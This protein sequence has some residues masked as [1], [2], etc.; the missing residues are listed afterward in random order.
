MFTTRI[1]LR[2]AKDSDYESLRKEMENRGF[3]RTITYAKVDYW[4]PAAEYNCM[5][6]R[7]EQVLTVAVKAATAVGFPPRQDNDGKNTKTSGILVTQSA[8]RR[9]AGLSE[10]KPAAAPAPAPAAVAA[11]VAKPATKVA[12]PSRPAKKK[13]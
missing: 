10:A 1:E 6:E 3:R 11:A 8:A 5:A 7:P 2:N 9:M 13:R 12:A 4:M